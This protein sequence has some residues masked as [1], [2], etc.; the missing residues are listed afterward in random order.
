MAPVFGVSLREDGAHLRPVARDPARGLKSKGIRRAWALRRAG[1]KEREG[2]RCLTWLHNPPRGGFCVDACATPPISG[3]LSSRALT[4][5]RSPWPIRN[6]AAIAR[7][8][9]RRRRSLSLRRT[10]RHS[11]AR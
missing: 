4:K 3:V 2:G 1:E 5:W 8:A 6:S 7:S 10:F 11:Q 9:N